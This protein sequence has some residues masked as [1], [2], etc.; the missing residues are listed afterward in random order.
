[1]FAVSLHPRRRW[2][3]FD[4]KL[5]SS[6]IVGYRRCISYSGPSMQMRNSHGMF[7]RGIDERVLVIRGSSGYKVRE[8]D[9][10]A[11]RQ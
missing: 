6:V 2:Y 10:R 9:A 4:E 5:Y 7:L 3:P 11:L 8:R 1:V